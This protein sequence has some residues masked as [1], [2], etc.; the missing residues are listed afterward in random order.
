MIDTHCHL[1]PDMDDGAADM[2]EAA[3]MAAL[4]VREGITAVCCTPHLYPR[5]QAKPAR[6]YAARD[7]C[8]AELQAALA[9]RGIPLRLYA[10]AEVYLSDDIFYAGDLQPAALNGGRH[11]LVEFTT[12]ALRLFRARQYIEEVRRRGFIPVLAHAERYPL[13]QRDPELLY[14]LAEEGCLLQINVDSLAGQAP[15]QNVRLAWMLA[16]DG[17]A[18]LLATDAHNMAHRPPLFASVRCAFPAELTAAQLHDM[19]EAAAERVLGAH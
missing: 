1:L 5:E 18:A 8:L 17:V 2:S 19:S 3:A 11:L 14:A 16:R 10:G 4:A 6:F 15:P 7:R 9:E 12:R 13:A